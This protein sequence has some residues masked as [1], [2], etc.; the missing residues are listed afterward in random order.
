MK[1]VFIY[2]ISRIPSGKKGGV[3]KNVPP[4]VLGA[5]LIDKLLS[6]HNFDLKSHGELILANSIGT[7]GNMARNCQLRSSLPKEIGA[8]SIDFQCG[9]SYKAIQLASAQVM[10]GQCDWVLAGGIESNSLQAERNYH[11][12]DPRRISNEPIQTADFSP[13]GSVSLAQAAEELA[14]KYRISKDQMMDWM[15][16]SHQKA[17]ESFNEGLFNNNVFPFSSDQLQ[18]ESIHT[19]LS[20]KLLERA[21]SDSLIDRTNTADFHD[22]AGIILMGTKEFG[23]RSGF[24]SLGKITE[25]TFVGLDPNYS[26]EGALVASRAMFRQIDKELIDIF[27]ICESYAVK[28]LAFAQEFQ[29]PLEKINVLGS[30]LAMGHPFAASGIINILNLYVGLQTKGLKRGLVSAGIAGG[31]GVSMVLEIER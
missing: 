16:R 28:P 25:T 22:G 4:E 13:N 1:E 19:N 10:S 31:L 21:Q 14:L 20:K 11:L 27:E 17:S 6:R 3:Y 24:K 18:D 8:T 15:L 29:I 12:N 30:N 5:F 23:E 26:P 2:H 9:G 7:M